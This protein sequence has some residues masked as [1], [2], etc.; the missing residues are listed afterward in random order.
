MR[1]PRTAQAGSA[2]PENE[3][4][5]YF[6]SFSAGLPEDD[7]SGFMW[8]DGWRRSDVRQEAYERWF[9]AREP[10]S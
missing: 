9:M 5:Q 2:R 7:E 8:A 4:R 1:G 3:G 10:R 6:A